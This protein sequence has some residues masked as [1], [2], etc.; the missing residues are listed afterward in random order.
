MII[1]T[2][3]PRKICHYIHLTKLSTNN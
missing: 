1:S 3:A 2:S